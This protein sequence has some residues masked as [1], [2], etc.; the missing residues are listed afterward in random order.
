MKIIKKDRHETYQ[1]LGEYL[2]NQKDTVFFNTEIEKWKPLK[3]R[4]QLGLYFTAFDFLCHALGIFGHSARYMFRKGLEE[5]YHFKKAT[6][7]F[8]K[9]EFTG[10]EEKVIAP[11]PLSECNRIEEF[12]AGFDGLFIEAGE[13]VPS[14]DMSKYVNEWEAIKQAELEKKKEA[15]E[16]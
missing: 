16:V 11:I 15:L 3:T 14:V 10:E 1:E 9:N 13:S 7:V 12:Q 4:P 6:G 2:K 8:K 5:K